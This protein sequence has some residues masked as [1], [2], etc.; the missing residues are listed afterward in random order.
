M[1][2]AKTRVTCPGD[3]RTD[4]H[5]HPCFG[6]RIMSDRFID[7][8]ATGRQQLLHL[9]RDVCNAASVL[10]DQTVIKSGQWAERAQPAIKACAILQR[11]LVNSHPAVSD[12]LHM[13]G[14]EI[15]IA[16]AAQSDETL[17][18][19]RVQRIRE[20]IHRVQLSGSGL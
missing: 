16:L 14:T 17:F 20:A 2:R 3:L 19:A 4:R 5:A 7:G 10:C 15:Q 12:D 1:I 11:G 9:L 6:I 18:P 8:G 13:L